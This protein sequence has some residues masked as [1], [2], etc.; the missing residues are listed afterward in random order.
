MQQ[1]VSNFF[2]K[3]L[4]CSIRK[5]L[6]NGA[7]S[8][9]FFANFYLCSIRKNSK[10]WSSHQIFCKLMPVQHKKKLLK[11]EQK[12]TK[13]FTNLR[14]FYLVY[15]ILKN[16]PKDGAVTKF[17]ANFYL[18]SIRKNFQKWSKVTKFFANFYL[19]SIKKTSINR[20]KSPNFLQTFIC[21]A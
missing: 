20:A 13:F 4:Q 11:M 16:P 6:K 5:T 3:L 19:C 9:Q 1:T 21:V 14:F 8:H 2:C 7:K 17:F 10:K 18:C 12:T 15:M